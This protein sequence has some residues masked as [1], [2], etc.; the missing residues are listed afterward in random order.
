MLKPIPFG[1]IP[2]SFNF[3]LPSCTDSAGRADVLWPRRVKMLQERSTCSR[4]RHTCVQSYLYE[5]IVNILETFKCCSVGRSSASRSYG[6]RQPERI[7]SEPDR[8]RN[9]C[10]CLMCYRFHL[11]VASTNA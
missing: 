7:D 2:F 9:C 6:M 3:G 8:I 4:L 11:C 10:S 5:Q 1:S